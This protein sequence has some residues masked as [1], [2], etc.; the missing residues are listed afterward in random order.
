VNWSDN[1]YF[2]PGLDTLRRREKERLDPSTYDH[3]WEGGYLVNS[4]AQVM[5]GKWREAEF[6]PKATWDGPYQ[7]GDFGYAQDPT[8]AVRCY[9]HGDT[10]YVSHEAGGRAI[11]LDAIGGKV[12]EAIPGFADYVSRWDSASPGSISIV[13]RSGVPKAEGAPKWPGSVDDGIRFLRSFREIVV[14]PRCVNTI[15]EMRLYS[16]KVDRL[17]GDVLAVLVDA[18]NHW[19]DALRYAV[20]PLIKGF[21]YTPAYGNL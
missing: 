14:H 11:E 6:E 8:A 7:G 13:K 5:A 12:N 2:P 1:P 15:K 9:I 20:S 10:L 18:N 3:V 19:I 4:E 16:Y 17:T 21:V